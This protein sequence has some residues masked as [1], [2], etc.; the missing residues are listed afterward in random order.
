MLVANSADG[1]AWSAPARATTARNASIPTL[2]A[3]PDGRVTVVYYTQNRQARLD[4]EAAWSRGG[5]W[6]RPQ[7][8]SAQPM[9]LSWLPTTT[10]GSMLADYVS[11]TTTTDGRVLAVWALASEPWGGKRRQAIYATRLP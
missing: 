8:L 11:A 2:A 9:D 3:G 4:A 6:S 7:R 1:I 5:A 10:Q